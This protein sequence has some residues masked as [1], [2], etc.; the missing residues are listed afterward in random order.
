MTKDLD[1]VAEPLT[2]PPPTR[3]HLACWAR[4][5]VMKDILDECGTAALRAVDLRQPDASGDAIQN[6]PWRSELSSRYSRLLLVAMQQAPQAIGRP[7][8]RALRM[9]PRDDYLHANANKAAG[10]RTHH[11]N[12]ILTCF[13]SSTIRHR[14]EIRDLSSSEPRNKNSFD[15][16]HRL[17]STVSPQRS[18][19]VHDHNG[20][21]LAMID[22]KPGPSPYRCRSDR[23]ISHPLILC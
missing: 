22:R 17:G 2:A 9:Q 4:V 7:G 12:N 15:I 16:D 14:S 5:M 3:Q 20:V 10:S 6:T 13:L 1:R 11:L 23:L 8:I 18:T 19:I 21:S